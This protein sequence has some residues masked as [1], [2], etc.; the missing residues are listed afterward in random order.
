M[1]QDNR[2]SF[3]ND[4]CPQCHQPSCARA[5][6]GVRFVRFRHTA[7]YSGAL[8]IGEIEVFI[9]G[10]VPESDMYSL[11]KSS[12]NVASVTSSA[13]SGRGYGTA[14]GGACNQDASKQ[15]RVQISGGSTNDIQKQYKVVDDRVN[16]G[17]ENDY[18][19]KVESS[20][21]SAVTLYL[22]DYFNVTYVRVWGCNDCAISDMNHLTVD[23]FKDQAITHDIIS[24]PASRVASRSNME[25]IP[26]LSYAYFNFLEVEQDSPVAYTLLGCCADLQMERQQTSDFG[27]RTRL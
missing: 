24:T 20:S 10:Y 17:T 2:A 13:A 18:C 9:D 19:L 27:L 14:C 21:S 4:Q 11:D 1:N 16:R 3:N 15:P 23:V 7:R 8:E 12:H 22:G 6:H 25:R 5:P 26:T